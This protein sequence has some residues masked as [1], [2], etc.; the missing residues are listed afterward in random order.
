MGVVTG[1]LHFGGLTPTKF[2]FPTSLK[3]R[4]TCSTSWPHPLLPADS[5]DP[6]LP[7]FGRGPEAAQDLQQLQQPQEPH[8]AQQTEEDQVALDVLRVEAEAGGGG[9]RFL[10]V[11]LC[12]SNHR[13]GVVFMGKGKLYLMLFLI[14][15]GGFADMKLNPH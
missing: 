14:G 6:R 12:S 4:K 7:R 2:D 1:L 11:W 15:G 9:A 8:Q 13:R 3:R 5:P 10:Q